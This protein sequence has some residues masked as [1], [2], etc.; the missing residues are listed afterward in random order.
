[1][2]APALILHGGAGARRSRDYSAEIVH[3][4]AVVEAMR[5]RLEAGGSALDV[6]VETTVLLEDSGLYVAGRGSSPN[7]AGEYELDAS[8]MDGATRRAGPSPPFRAFAIR[9]GR[10]G[11]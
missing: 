1:M 10:R 11:R 3:M 8:L 2:P 6:A 9:S 7:L 4:R 5:D